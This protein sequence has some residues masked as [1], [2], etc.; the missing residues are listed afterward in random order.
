MS[1]IDPYAL[2]REKYVDAWNDTLL[3]MWREQITHLEVLDTHALLDSLTILPVKYDS[4]YAEMSISQE[5]KEYGIWQD[6]GV[7]KEVPRPDRHD[8]YKYREKSSDGRYAGKLLR[9][10]IRDRR[11]WFSRKYF[12]SVMS[13]KEFL[14]DHWGREY[15]RLISDALMDETMRN[16]TI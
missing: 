10:K 7:G 14:A 16:T 3:T 11:P 6:Y 12:Q 9:E 2:T 4:D 5:F 1:G 8:A 13:M 15:C